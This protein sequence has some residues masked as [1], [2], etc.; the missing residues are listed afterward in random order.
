MPFQQMIDLQF[1]QS[2]GQEKDQT[3]QEQISSLKFSD[4]YLAVGDQGGRVILFTYKTQHQSPILKNDIYCPSASMVPKFEFQAHNKE[5]DPIRS[6]EIRSK[7]IEM[8]F[9]RDNILLTANEKEVKMW[10]LGQKQV[11]S[12]GDSEFPI[13]SGVKVTSTLKKTF[14]SIQNYHINSIHAQNDIFLIA[15][16][17][18]IKQYSIENIHESLLICNI[19]PT[20]MESILETI[21]VAQFNDQSDNIINY[22]TDLGNIH[23]LDKRQ[24]QQGS[25]TSFGVDSSVFDLKSH[26]DNL[27]IRTLNDMYIYDVRNTSQPLLELPLFR[28]IYT[29][30]PQTNFKIALKDDVFATGFY[31]Q[32]VTI[33]NANDAYQFK[34][35]RQ[36]KRS[37]SD[38]C[39]C[40]GGFQILKDGISTTDQTYNNDF[41]GVASCFDFSDE[42]L[43]VSIGGNLYLY[44]WADQKDSYTRDQ[45]GSNEEGVKYISE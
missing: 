15:D 41:I 26:N 8:E 9:V 3:D 20:N 16:D 30:K 29:G 39:S 10:K 40:V 13:K 4:Q 12:K 34:A 44:G 6:C 22:G 11:W 37:K 28:A 23:I 24:T 19:I 1:C 25:S 7:V 2:F 17:F 36:L 14:N 21:K 38:F 43:S 31:G 27:Y 45:T 35:T 33:G 5:F 42:L 18:S 32:C